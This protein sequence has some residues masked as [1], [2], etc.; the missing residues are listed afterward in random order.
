[1]NTTQVDITKTIDL[2]WLTD[3]EKDELIISIG[4]LIMEAALLRLSAELTDE[5]QETFDQFMETN[6]SP[7]I[8]FKHL[9][10]H[11][12]NF[13]RILEEERDNFMAEAARVF[14]KDGE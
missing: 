8:L 7:E 9:L 12:K 4:D 11:H 5:Q 2:S 14:N 1:M 3:I 10:D 13:E 6:P